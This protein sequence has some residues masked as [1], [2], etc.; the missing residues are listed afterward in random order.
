VA[1]AAV[2]T[3]TWRLSLSMAGGQQ[4]NGVTQIAVAGGAS[5][6]DRCRSGC[7]CR[8]SRTQ[9]RRGGSAPGYVGPLEER[10]LPRQQVRNERGFGVVQMKQLARA[11]RSIAGFARKNFVGQLSTTVR[12]RS[13]RSRS[14]LLW[15]ARIIAALRLR[16]VFSASVM[17]ALSVGSSA[18]R[19]ASSRQE[20]H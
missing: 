10:L 9:D 12:S 7:S 6:G 1:H 11:A 3:R 2:N 8:S 14:S 19:H 20:L 17:Y 5:R 18:K 16:Q 15:V 13:L 4:L